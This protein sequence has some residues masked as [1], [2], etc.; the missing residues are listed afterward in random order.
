MNQ[1]RVL[2]ILTVLT[3]VLITTALITTS[4]SVARGDR[5]DVNKDFPCFIREPDGGEPR[6]TRLTS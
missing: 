4:L 6:I 5:A 1:K 2:A 3:S